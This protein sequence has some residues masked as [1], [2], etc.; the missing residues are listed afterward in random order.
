MHSNDN[1]TIKV[2]YQSYERKY[3]NT[4]EHYIKIQHDL[5]KKDLF[6]N[7]LNTVV[8][9]YHLLWHSDN[10]P[11]EYFLIWDHSVLYHS[12]EDMSFHKISHTQV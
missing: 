1:T 4:I 10:L 6:S 8:Y 7:L 2:E 12:H 3:S 5:T 9:L 11:A